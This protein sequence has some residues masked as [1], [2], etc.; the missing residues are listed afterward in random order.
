VPAGDVD[1]VQNSL[2]DTSALVIEVSG[3]GG[4]A[5]PELLHPAAGR[6]IGNPR[7]PVER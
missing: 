5:R 6:S 7:S 1:R 4:D 2:E 3:A